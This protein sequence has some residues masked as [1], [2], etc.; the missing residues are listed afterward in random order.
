MKRTIYLAKKAGSK[1]RP[2]VMYPWDDTLFRLAEDADVVLIN[3]SIRH[4]RGVRGQWKNLQEQFLEKET[5]MPPFK[6]K[7]IWGVWYCNPQRIVQKIKV[8]HDRISQQKQLINDLRKENKKFRKEKRA[9]C[10]KRKT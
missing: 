1:S 10:F 3:P 8:L 9:D 7:V 5:L 2:E 6:I 4:L